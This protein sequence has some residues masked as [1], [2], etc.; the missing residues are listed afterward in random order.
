MSTYKEL[1][2]AARK[3]LEENGIADAHVHAWYLLAHVF[4]IKR[5]DF[6]I[7]GDNETSKDK[8]LVYMEL[9]KKKP[10]IHPFNTLQESKNLWDLCLR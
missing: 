2:K 9:I 1:F 5:A 8:E 6:F 10:C 4:G 3:F 7:G